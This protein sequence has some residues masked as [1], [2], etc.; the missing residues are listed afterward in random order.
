MDLVERSFAVA[1]LTSYFVLIGL[2]AYLL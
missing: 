2:L 1:A